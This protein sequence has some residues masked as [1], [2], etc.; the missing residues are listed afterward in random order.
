MRRAS[1]RFWLLVSVL[2]LA[3]LAIQAATKP[4][5][6][7]R[8]NELTLAGFQPG[9][10]AVQV[11][12]RAN[13]QYFHTYRRSIRQ[14]GPTRTIASKYSWSNFCHDQEL[15]I[16]ATDNVIQSATV[17]RL[18]GSIDADCEVGL[19]PNEWKPG[20]GLRFGDPCSALLA[21]YGKPQS[22]TTSSYGDS[23]LESYSYE[24]EWSGAGVPNS[25][26]VSCDASTQNVIEI[27]LMA[28]SPFNGIS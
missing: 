13:R 9:Q 25:L 20:R 7:R 19:K 3:A 16:T 2:A 11:A 21:T 12:E 23:K 10:D 6:S 26:E 27:K 4:G 8:V 28:L 15:A 14:A 24:F 1:K 17:R 5:G 18:R 22:Q